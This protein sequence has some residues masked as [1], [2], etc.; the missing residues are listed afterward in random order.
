MIKDIKQILKNTPIV[1]PIAITQSLNNEK[2]YFILRDEMQEVV[3]YDNKE[4]LKVNKDLTI[5][6]KKQIV[7]MFPV[8]RQ[9]SFIIDYDL[10]QKLNLNTSNNEKN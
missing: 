9:K 3:V 4:N 2:I 10:K 8:L 6:E 7:T 5:E 1:Y